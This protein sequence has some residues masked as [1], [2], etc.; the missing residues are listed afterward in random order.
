LLPDYG[1]QP[2]L[3][4]WLVNASDTLR[5][6]PSHFFPVKAAARFMNDDPPP[7]YTATVIWGILLPSYIAEHELEAPA[8]LP[9]TVEELADRMRSDFGFGR[10]RDVAAVLDFL[11]IAR[12]A[13]ETG[14]GWV[15]HFRDLGS[16]DREIS[17]ALLSEYRSTANKSRPAKTARDEPEL[18]D[19]P[20]PETLFES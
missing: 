1:R 9:F 3:S 15:I 13:S 8:D 2:S 18:G 17:Q 7:L 14:T 16:I 10:K 6:L 5:G 4:T 12:L 19:A 20:E 11:K